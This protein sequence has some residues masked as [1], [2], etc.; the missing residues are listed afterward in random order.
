MSVDPIGRSRA[1]TTVGTPGSATGGPSARTATKA[2]RATRATATA[3]A[4]C[5]WRQRRRRDTGPN[6]GRPQRVRPHG[7]SR[8][9]GATG[10]TGPADLRR[11]RG[12][13]G[14]AN[15]KVSPSR[16][17][18]HGQVASSSGSAGGSASMA[19]VSTPL[20]PSMLLGEDR[21]HLVVGHPRLALDPRV[22]VGHQGER[23]EAHR[24]LPG[25]GRLGHPRHA[26]DRPARLLVPPALRPG[27][28][29]RTVDDDQRAA[30]L[31]REA[32][33]P[34]APRRPPDALAGRTAPRTPRG[35]PRP[36]RRR[37]CAA[38]PGAVDDLVDDDD[39]AGTELGRSE[40]T[41]H[42]ARTWRTPNE[43]SAQRFAR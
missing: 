6:R 43:R 18:R 25:D 9:P 24:Q 35:P 27:R 3:R 23:G 38:A 34:R 1:D 5:D 31:D 12:H 30:V 10:P 17:R 22:V 28:E 37:R 41:A 16:A 39:R 21:Q 19:S 15:G 14:S 26:D 8:E 11:C 13:V 29:P 40:P 7:G 20:R 36:L 2:A 32:G 4:A 42:G 33:L